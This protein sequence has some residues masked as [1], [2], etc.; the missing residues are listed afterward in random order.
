MK[1]IIEQ[2]E[3]ATERQADKL[4]DGKQWKCSDCKELI[5]PGHEQPTSNNPY[6]MPICQ[7]CANIKYK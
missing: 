6:S 1:D 2:M 7:K 4:F 5:Q 3:D